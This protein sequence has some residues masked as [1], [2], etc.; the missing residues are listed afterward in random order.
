MEDHPTPQEIQAFIEG[1]LDRRERE[2]MLEHLDH[3]PLYVKLLA[4]AVRE[5][6]VVRRH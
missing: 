3:C 6:R 4:D 5:K 1:R 2:R